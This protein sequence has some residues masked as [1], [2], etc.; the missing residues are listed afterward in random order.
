MTSIN[1]LDRVER[2]SENE[3]PGAFPLIGG[4]CNPNSGSR[5]IG[6]RKK[7]CGV[8]PIPS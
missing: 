1:T 3:T 8:L 4:H 2:L 7:I 5:P 6:E